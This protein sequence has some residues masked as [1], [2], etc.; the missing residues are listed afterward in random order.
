MRVLSLPALGLR[1]ERRVRKAGR[2]V[3]FDAVVAYL[4]N[5]VGVPDD[6]ARAGL[7]LARVVGRLEGTTDDEQRLCL[8]IPDD[9]ERAA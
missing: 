6:R 1:A 2:P 4:V 7:R 5:E 8:Y 3:P 9:R